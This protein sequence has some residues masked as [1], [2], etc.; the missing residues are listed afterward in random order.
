MDKVVHE[1]DA[2]RQYSNT[3]T[4]MSE[5]IDINIPLLKDKLFLDLLVTDSYVKNKIGSVLHIIRIQVTEQTEFCMLIISLDYQLA[6]ATS[7]ICY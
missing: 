5:K 2:E 1:L 3:S 4:A 6:A 7:V